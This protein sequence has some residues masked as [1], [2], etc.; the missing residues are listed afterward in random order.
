MEKPLTVD[1]FMNWMEMVGASTEDDI[2]YWAGY[3]GMQTHQHMLV[4]FTRPAGVRDLW[5]DVRRGRVSVP[6]IH[7]GYTVPQRN[8]KDD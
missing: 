8:T 5:V 2:M 7:N 6:V 4:K 3:F 1:E